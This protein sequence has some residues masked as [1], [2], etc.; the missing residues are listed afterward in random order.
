MKFKGLINMKVA[1]REN[2]CSFQW[3]MRFFLLVNVKILAIV[4]HEKGLIALGPG[5]KNVTQSCN[6]ML[7]TSVVCL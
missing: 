6:S 1:S 5:Q 3:S 7:A 4:E 2:S